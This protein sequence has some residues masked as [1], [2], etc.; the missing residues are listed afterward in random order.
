MKAWTLN[1]FL[2]CCYYPLLTLLKYLLLWHPKV[3]ARV[4]FEAKNGKDLG[5]QSWQE[6]GVKADLCFEFSSEGEFQQVASLIHDALKSGKKLELVFF[7]PSVEKTIVDLARNY[8]TQ[9]RYLRFPLFH[10]SFSSWV[11]SD[12]LILV[13]YDLFPELLIFALREQTRVQLL[14]MTFKKERSRGSGP[15]W[16]KKQ[17]LKAASS[18]IYAA[19]EDQEQGRKLGFPGDC[20]DFRMVQIHRRIETRE[21]SLKQRMPYFQSYLQRLEDYPPQRRLILGNAWPEDISLLKGLSQDTLLLVVPH[22]LQDT[23][24][25]MIAVALR[26]AGRIPE[27][28]SEKTPELPAGNTFIINQKG[29]LCELYSDF[30]RAYVGGGFGASVHSILEPLIAGSDL[31][32]CGPKHQRSTEYDIAR[33]Y[34]RIS[35]VKNARDFQDWLNRTAPQEDS[36]VKLNEVIRNYPEYSKGV[37]EC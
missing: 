32:A 17:F 22:Q 10:E 21:Q 29:I 33:F 30:G 15:S 16:F 11:T 24:L 3:R 5:S 31:L 6:M 13:R 23:N 4:E 37:L 18:I 35:E 19:Q 12:R 34:G 25:N 8:S 36:R 2:W 27:I 28:I 1:L 26:E 7:S 20:F 14:W 9:I